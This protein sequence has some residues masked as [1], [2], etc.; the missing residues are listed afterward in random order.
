M[1]WRRQWEGMKGLI[2]RIEGRRFFMMIMSDF[3]I[4][5]DRTQS[6]RMKVVKT[7]LREFG[8]HGIGSRVEACMK[9]MREMEETARSW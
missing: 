8:R 3:L 1:G 5:L 6:I 9:R 7:R 2:G 4:R